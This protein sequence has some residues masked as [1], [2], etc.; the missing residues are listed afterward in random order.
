MSNLINR[1]KGKQE[2]WLD[3]SLEKVIIKMSEITKKSARPPA[4]FFIEI[5]EEKH[6]IFFYLASAR[7]LSNAR[8]FICRRN[9]TNMLNHYSS[10]KV[11][12]LFSI[13]SPLIH[14]VV[15]DI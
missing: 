1:N 10:K 5:P 8:Y 2:V 14:E 4:L 3:E 15:F 7:P 13:I 9:V 12:A 6:L 11:D